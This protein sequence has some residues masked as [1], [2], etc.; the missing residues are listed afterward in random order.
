MALLRIPVEPAVLDAFCKRWKILKLEEFPAAW[1][2]F[3]ADLHLLVTVAPDANW[4]L[5]DHNQV[6]YELGA[7][8]GK[9]IELVSRRAIESSRSELMRSGILE[10]A[11]L[12][13][14]AA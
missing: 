11:R 9:T 8:L 5:I 2:G 6:E 7:L 10:N 14:A 4:G 13:Y 1:G 12:I 3:E